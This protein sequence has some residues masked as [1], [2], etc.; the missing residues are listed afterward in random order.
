MLLDHL[1]RSSA[2]AGLD[3]W[4]PNVAKRH[5]RCLGANIPPPQSGRAELDRAGSEDPPVQPTSRPRSR[6]SQGTGSLSCE[7]GPVSCSEGPAYQR[8]GTADSWPDSAFA[9]DVPDE[10]HMTDRPFECP[11]YPT[12]EEAAGGLQETSIGDPES[13]GGGRAVE[14]CRTWGA[15][16]SAEHSCFR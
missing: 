4:P 14:K 3:S 8:N 15:V 6:R 9:F 1:L 2:V 13:G 5:L 10:W 16:S 7:N 12:V 11:P